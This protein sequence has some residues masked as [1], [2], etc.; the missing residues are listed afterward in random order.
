[1]PSFQALQRLM[2][3]L[4]EGSK[5]LCRALGLNV[6]FS[7]FTFLRYQTVGK[8]YTE[9]TKVAIRRSRTTALLRALIHIVPVTVALWEIVLNWNTY[10]VGYDVYNLIYYQF[11]AKLHEIAIQA[12]LSAVIFSYV[13]YELM[14]GDGIPFG[15]LFSGLQISQ[16]SYLWSMEFWGTVSSSSISTKSKLCLL[17]VVTASIFLAAVT[18]PSSAI[19]LVPRLDYWPAGSTNIWIN[20]TSDSLWPARSANLFLNVNT[21][22]DCADHFFSTNASDVPLQCLNANTSDLYSSACPSHGWEA[23]QKW[24]Y[25]TYHSIAPRYQAATGFFDTPNWVEVTGRGSQRRLTMNSL[26]DPLKGYDQDEI[27]ATTQQSV[28]ADALTETGGLWA[29]SVSN[30]STSGHGSVLQRQDAVHAIIS[31]YY[32]PYTDASCATDVIHG[33]HDDKPVAFPVPPAV[34]ADLMLDQTKYNDSILGIHSFVYPNITRD[35]ILGTPG[36][37][38]GVRLKWVELPRDPFNG[39]AIGAVILLPRL[40]AN[41]TQGLVVCN[42]G[43]GWGPTYINT[44]SFAGGSTFTTSVIDW[45]NMD[46]PFNP[47]VLPSGYPG[48]TQAESLASDT[49]VAFGLPFFPKSP[50]TVTEAW[51]NYLNP[52][53]PALNTTVINALMSTWKP[54]EELSSVEL[55]ITAKAALAGLLVNGLASIGATGTLQ[56]DIKTVV[57]PDSSSTFDR[58][59]WFSGKGDIFSVDPE[60]SRDWVKLRVESTINGYAYNMRGSSPKVAISFLL[61]YCIIALSHVLYAGLSGRGSLPIPRLQVDH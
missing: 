50:I 9:Q 27:Q 18:G 61:A 10:F 59:Y 28:V 58:D 56:G 23:I 29:H 20:V 34:V 57:Q 25:T 33:P 60:E 53:V 31:G 7:F 36:S 51:A 30:V 39:S 24:I 45:S 43:A 38:D 54:V 46:Y 2:K 17:S 44:S 41:L 49:V 14:L 4:K 26:F 47:K 19:L 55:T 40:K 35:Q 13:R 11:G 48:V 8:G 52:F 1:M 6:I 16:V 15:A 21:Y 3:Q 42:L 12:S 22:L 32:Q 37:I 5:T